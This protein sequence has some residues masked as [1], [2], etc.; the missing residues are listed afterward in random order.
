VIDRS[1]DLSL[2]VREIVWARFRNGGRSCLATKRVYVDRARATEFID[3]AHRHIAELEFGDPL[4]PET[5]VGP[6]A[7]LAAVRRLEDQVARSMKAG[8]RLMLGGMRF[9]PCG[10]PG[11]FFQPTILAEAP[12]ESRVMREEVLG[13]VLV[14]NAVSDLEEGLREAVSAWPDAR[15]ALVSSDRGV[16]SDAAALLGRPLAWVN[17]AP[18]E[19]EIFLPEAGV[20]AAESPRFFYRDRDADLAGV[21]G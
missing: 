18:T 9:R 5:D 17:R 10:L 6:L 2:A 13:P 14:V 16:A 20:L 7:T 3:Q 21:A 15:V 12:R 1:A 19:C 11:Y 8:A 4:R